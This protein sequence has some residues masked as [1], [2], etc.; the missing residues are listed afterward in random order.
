MPRPV[1]LLVNPSAGGGRAL[2][3]L[4]AVE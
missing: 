2:K 1:A 3:A 4:P